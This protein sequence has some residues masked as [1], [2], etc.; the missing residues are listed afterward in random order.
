MS[1]CR[2]SKAVGLGLFSTRSTRGRSWLLHGLPGA[3]MPPT[4]AS[5]RDMSLNL[6]ILYH[7]LSI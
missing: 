5:L 1:F 7:S 3:S 6:Y 4:R 2:A